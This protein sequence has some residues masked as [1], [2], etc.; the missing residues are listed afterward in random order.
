MNEFYEIE[1]ENKD[2]ISQMCEFTAEVTHFFYQPPHRGSKHTC[3]SSD[4]YYGYAECDW[5]WV[6]WALFDQDGE[7][8]GCGIGE[9]PVNIAMTDQQI[10]DYL[11]D[12]IT[13]DRYG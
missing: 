6:D 5:E 4:D 13:E 9:P 10:T 7:E 2:N 3:D 8:I 12:T 11:I 1:S